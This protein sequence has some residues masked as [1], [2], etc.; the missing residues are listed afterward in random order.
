MSRLEPRIVPVAAAAAD[1]ALV[2]RMFAIYAAHYD[3]CEPARFGADLAVKDYVILLEQQ[4]ELKGFST[5]AHFG[6]RASAGDVNVLF[7]GDTV[8]DRSA[9]GEQALS[10]SFAQLAGALHAQAPATP[11]YWL[12]I[13]KGHR[14]YRYLRLFARRFFPHEATHDAQ[15]AQLA[16]EVARARFGDDFDPRTGVIAFDRSHG[17]LKEDLAEVPGHIAA[18]PEGAFFLQR[19]PGYRHGHELVCLAQLTA[20][21]LRSVV[22]Q[23]FL[24]GMAHGLG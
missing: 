24:Q 14:T 8:I 15:L 22:R 23:A 19:N 18:R 20:G 16:A 10:R 6:F 9:W 17:H 2:A 7:S 5:V 21:N 1:G 11:L 3:A 12:L 4:G 13:S